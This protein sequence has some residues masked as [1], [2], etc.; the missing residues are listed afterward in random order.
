MYKFPAT[1]IS[2]LQGC[3]AGVHRGA[4]AG[5]CSPQGDIDAGDGVCDTSATTLPERLLVQL[6]SHTLWLLRRLAQEVLGE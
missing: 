4:A 5:V 1:E 6:F 3:A 2:Q